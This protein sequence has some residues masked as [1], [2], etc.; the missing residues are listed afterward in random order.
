MT[1]KWAEGLFKKFDEKFNVSAD[2]NR[3]KI[4]YS[5]IDG[6]YDDFSD[7]IDWW[8]NGFWGGIMWMLYSKTQNPLY[9]EAAELNEEKLDEALLGYDKL[10]HDVGFMWLPTSVANYKL[11]GNEKSKKRALLAASVL[12]S[13][14]NLKSGHIRA[15]NDPSP[16]GIAIIDCMMNLPLLYWASNETGDERFKNIAMQHADNTIQYHLRPDGSVKHIVI[17]DTE[18]GGI[19]REEEGQ[20][21]SVGSSWSRGQTWALYGFAISYMYTGKQEY[22]DAAKRVANYFIANVCDDWLPRCDFRSPKTPVIYDTTAG[23]IAACGLIQLSKLV[24]ENEKDMYLNAAISM[25]KAMEDRFCNFACETDSILQMGTERY[26]SDKGR[27]IHII[28][29]DYYYLMALLYLIDG[30]KE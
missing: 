18:N 6:K 24:S 29:G 20:G 17:Y 26:H 21:Y 15:W 27:H 12:A 16:N 2:R 13:R 7:R 23:A 1:E 19:V 5:T 28:Y 22:L 9:R 10:H 25:L 11:T 14:F 30:M 4:P 3:D 8:T